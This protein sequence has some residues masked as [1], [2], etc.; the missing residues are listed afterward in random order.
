MKKTE[1]RKV[2]EQLRIY[3]AAKRLNQSQF[4]LLCGLTQRTVSLIENEEFER[5]SLD[6]I[7]KVEDYVAH[8]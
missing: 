2:A 4:A 3:R 5:V 1:K 8:H 6:T 7:N